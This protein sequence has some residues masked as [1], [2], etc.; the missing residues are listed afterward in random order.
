MAR[1][2]NGC[3]DKNHNGYI[4][5]LNGARKCL[6]V[7]KLRKYEISVGEVIVAPTDCCD[8]TEMS[9]NQ[10]A[11]VYENDHNFGDIKVT[12]SVENGDQLLQSQ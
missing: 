6:H 1:S 5:E 10:C 3:W 4:D 11:V 12:E 8:M 7:D 2:S 9:T